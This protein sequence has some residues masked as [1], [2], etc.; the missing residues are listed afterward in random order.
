MVKQVEYRS[1]VSN[2]DMCGKTLT[3]WFVDG[4]TRFGPWANMCKPCHEKYGVGLGTGRGQL[5]Q[6]IRGK[7]LKQEG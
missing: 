4:K 7:W 6:H 1:G 3:D 2:C 5:Y